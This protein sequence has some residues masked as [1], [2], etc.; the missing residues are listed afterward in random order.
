[1]KR[2]LLFVLTVLPFIA[3]AQYCSWNGAYS[4][5][6]SPNSKIRCLNIFVNII[7]DVHPDTNNNFN[8]PDVYWPT[9]T[10]PNL[11]GINTAAIPTYLLDWMDTVFISGQLH[12]TCTRL[13][14]ESS[15]D[16][17]QIIGDFMVVNIKESTIWNLSGGFNQTLIPRAV[18]AFISEV[19]F[20]T[21][22]NHDEIGYYDVNNNTGALT[23]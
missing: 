12:G 20:H 10:D 5:G 22:N 21:I 2:I 14:G 6:I 17:L 13:Y 18:L 7:Y 16:S 4:A 23:F 1:M 15:F 9:I 8:N 19:G 3:I 11:E